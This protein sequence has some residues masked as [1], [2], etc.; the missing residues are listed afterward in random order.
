MHFPRL[1][2][3]LAELLQWPAHPELTPGVTLARS[4]MSKLTPFMFNERIHPRKPICLVAVPPERWNDGNKSNQKHF[5]VAG[6]LNDNYY[7]TEWRITNKYNSFLSVMHFQKVSFTNKQLV[8]KL[9]AKVSIRWGFYDPQGQLVDLQACLFH[10]AFGSNPMPLP[11]IQWHRRFDGQD[12]WPVARIK[13][14]SHCR[15]SW[16]HR[17]MRIWKQPEQVEKLTLLK[18]LALKQNHSAGVLNLGPRDPLSC[19]V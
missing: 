7:W 19:R 16:V 17:N 1:W 12:Y 4:S 10:I 15:W 5:S 9:Q 3:S 2:Q 6:A 11:V 18:L 8:S 14:E 13:G